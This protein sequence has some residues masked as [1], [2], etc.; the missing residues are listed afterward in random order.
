[1]VPMMRWR[2][3]IPVVILG[4][5]GAAVAMPSGLRSEQGPT[6]AS[7]GAAARPNTWSV[8]R[9]PWGHPDLQGVWS[10][11]DGTPFERPLS[12][13]PVSGPS[14]RGD[15]SQGGADAEWRSRPDGRWPGGGMRPPLYW[16]SGRSPV[17]PNREAIVVM[18][19][20]GRVP[21]RPEAEARRDYNLVHLTDSWEHHSPW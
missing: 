13:P 10:N 5:V 3:A 7:P 19:S 6:A 11:V 12:P 16:N 8:P 14:L 20:D 18:P 2:I 15:S 9:T 1:M 4:S 21:V 17:N